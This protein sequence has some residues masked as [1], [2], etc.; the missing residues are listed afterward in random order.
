MAV[1]KSVAPVLLDELPLEL[2]SGLASVRHF[3]DEFEPVPDGF[4]VEREQVWRM[5]VATDRR[6]AARKGFLAKVKVKPKGVGDLEFLAAHGFTMR[7]KER[8]RLMGLVF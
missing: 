4:S 1:R 5:A 3:F 6:N 8:A 7:D 2:R